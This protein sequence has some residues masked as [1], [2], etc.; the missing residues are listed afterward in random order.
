MRSKVLLALLVLSSFSLWAGDKIQPLD[1]K[2]GLWE[3]TSTTAMTGMPP[4]PP[5]VLAN[6]SAEQRA[7]MEAAMGARSGGAPK[8]TARKTCITQEKMDKQTAFS[9]EHKNCT[10][11]VVSSSSRKLE[12]KLQCTEPQNAT[13]SGTVQVE[14]LNSETLKGS[15]RMASTGGGRTMNVNSDFTSRYLGSACGDVK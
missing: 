14:V 9:D 8:T 7:K 10:H 4:I 2:L 3:V 6:M 12:I 5:D 11:T 1:I 15:M 13:M